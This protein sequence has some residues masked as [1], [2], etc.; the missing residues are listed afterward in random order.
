MSNG[1]QTGIEKQQ[2]VQKQS[3]RR[4]SEERLI[5][6]NNNSR[7]ASRRVQDS[8][9]D[10]EDVIEEVLAETSELLK[11]SSSSA[12][13]ESS[14]EEESAKVA[15]D[16]MTRKVKK[17]KP[18]GLTLYISNDRNTAVLGQAGCSPDSTHLTSS[19]LE[20]EKIDQKVPTVSGIVEERQII[21]E[22]IHGT[23]MSNTDNNGPIK[24]RG[25]FQR[26]S[27]PDP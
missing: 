16:G 27:W 21:D 3:N 17:S 11:P 15:E 7:A 5:I 10:A 2:N 1:I 13:L 22:I 24:K 4:R 23:G 18:R 25:G 20:N 9:R 12:S 26:V 14:A 6:S 19:T 8:R